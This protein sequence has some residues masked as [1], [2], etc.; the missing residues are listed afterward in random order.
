MFAMLAILAYLRACDRD[1]GVGWIRWLSMAWLL[2]LAAMLSKAVAVTLPVVLIVLDVYPLRRLK[3]RSLGDSNSLNLLREKLPFL[4]LSVVFMGLA[5]LGKHSNESIRSVQSYGFLERFSQSCYG[6]W[7]YLVKSLLPIGLTAYYPLPK[8]GELLRWPFLLA[9]LAT[10]A[11]TGLAFAMRRRWP[12]LLTVWVAYLVVLAPNA[13]IV[14]IGNQ[15]AA[16]RYSYAATIAWVPLLAYGFMWT[17][18][19]LRAR[20][21]SMAVPIAGSLVAAGMLGVLTWQQCLTWRDTGALWT[22]VLK[23]VAGTSATPHFNLGAD[24]VRRGRLQEGADQYREALRIDPSSP[25]TH[26]L[27]GALFD[28]QGKHREAAAE[29]QRAVALEPEYA[30]AQNNLGASLARDGDLLAATFRFGE[31]VRLKPK[32]PL[33]QRN[34]GVALAR[35]ERFNEAIKHLTEAARLEPD[36][37]QTRNDLG[38]ALANA[39]RL[40]EAIVQFRETVR[41]NPQSASGHINLGMALEERNR[42]DEAI[43]HY[44]A[45]VRLEPDRADTR[46]SLASALASRGR[47]REASAQFKAVLRLEPGNEKARQSLER[48][49]RGAGP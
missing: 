21:T 22:N 41:I 37:A 12:A 48:I 42:F 6:T 23:Q 20:S 24:L 38:L 4:A 8:S 13:G 10:V 36:R 47:L 33:A 9:I 16:D 44:E 11:A 15:I 5:V 2:A 40:D 35:R 31:A 17:T 49:E 29:F 14:H 39:G 34:L 18:E 19:K 45:A 43:D 30:D 1:G 27:L 46:S 25:D 26:N 3:L 7:F 32:F 28:K